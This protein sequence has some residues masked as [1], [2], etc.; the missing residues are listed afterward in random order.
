[1][2]KLILITIL[3]FNCGG[4]EEVIPD[5]NSYCIFQ[6]NVSANAGDIGTDSWIFLTCIEDIYH[7]H[8]S[9]DYAGYKSIDCECLEQPSR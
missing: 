7:Q 4:K 2:K 9:S 5:P 1:M 6:R 8:S 3:L